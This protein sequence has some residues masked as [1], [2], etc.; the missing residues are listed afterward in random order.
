M[1][2]RH[3]TRL[4]NAPSIQADRASLAPLRSASSNQQTDGNPYRQRLAQTALGLSIFL[5]ALLGNLA[6]SVAQEIRVTSDQRWLE[7]Q[8]IRGNVTYKGNQN[9]PARVG[10]RLGSVGQ[11]I[12]TA[13]RSTSILNIDT[14]IGVVRVAENTDLQVRRLSVLSDGARVTILDV[15]QGQARL[16]VRPFSHPNSRL[17]IQTPSGIAGVRGTEFGVS[18]DPTGKTGIA[19]LEGAVEANAQGRAVLVDAGF[20]SVII[21]GHP[22]TPPRPIDRELRLQNIRWRRLGRRVELLAS[23]DPANSVLINGEEVNVSR[24][25][26]IDVSIPQAYNRPYLRVLVRNPL[27]EERNYRI[28]VREIDGND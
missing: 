23:V 3:T 18:V 26:A 16:Q 28:R 24:I 11:G 7:V 9:R 4:A 2:H 21:P 1:H 15:S 10:D 13:G 5:G 20:A 22:P 12:A 6:P 14:G 27:G 8:Q 17:E 25:G 19:T